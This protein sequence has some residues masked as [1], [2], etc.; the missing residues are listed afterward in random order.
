[1]GSENLQQEFGD[2]LKFDLSQCP[3]APNHLQKCMYIG[4][5]EKKYYKKNKKRSRKTPKN[6]FK[7]SIQ[8]SKNQKPTSLIL[9]KEAPLD[10]ELHT[11]DY[12]RV[13]QV[14]LETFSNGFRSASAFINQIAESKSRQEFIQRYEISAGSLYAAVTLGHNFESIVRGLRL[15]CRLEWRDQKAEHWISKTTGSYGKCR[16]VLEDRHYYIESAHWK[17]ASYYFEL[18]GLKD[19]F[20][21]EI[22][23]FS[24]KQVMGVGLKDRWEDEKTT[25]MFQPIEEENGDNSQS[26]R[27]SY[28]GFGNVERIHYFEF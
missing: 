22:F 21:G 13:I 9:K 20:I 4:K 23:K 15:H 10:E 2:G 25:R 24:P 6:K 5:M 7:P 8:R 28:L 11:K 18:E 17:V 19:C 1:M 27:V 16:L 12:E 14:Y 3:L 26:G